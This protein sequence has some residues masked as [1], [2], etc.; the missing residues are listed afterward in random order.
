MDNLKTIKITQERHKQLL[1]KGNK[2]ETF[3]ALFK[4]LLDKLCPICNKKNKR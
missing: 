4:R 1:S 2:G 3:D